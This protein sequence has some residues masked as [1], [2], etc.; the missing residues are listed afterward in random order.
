MHSNEDGQLDKTRTGAYL[1]FVNM[2]DNS[3][4]EVDSVLKL[5][6]ASV[7][8]LDQLFKVF[9]PVSSPQTNCL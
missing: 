1:H 8:S 3:I 4:M 7:E 6:D 2:K 9:N 5:I